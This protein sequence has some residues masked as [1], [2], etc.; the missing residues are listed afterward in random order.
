L[1]SSCRRTT[2]GLAL[3]AFAAGLCGCSESPKSKAGHPAQAVMRVEV[4]KPQRHTVQRAVGEPGQL[5][6]FETTPIHAKIAGY[7]RKVNV[8]IGYEIKKGEVLAE[9]YVPELEAE[10][11]QKSAAVEQAQAKKAQAEAVVKVAVAAIASSE[12]KLTEVQAGVKRSEADLVRWQQEFRRIE[13]LFNERAQTGT[14]LDETRSKL[15]ASEASRDEVRAQVKSAEAAVAEAR[16]SLDQTRSDVTATAASIGVAREDVRR[17]EAMLGYTRIEAPYDGIITRRNVDTGHLTRPGSDAPPLFIAAR[18]DVVTIVVDIPETYAA[19]VEKGDRA[20]VKLQAMKGRIVE[21]TV[22]RTSWA[23]DS[24]TR[25]VRTEIDIPNPGGKLRPG[26]YAYATVIVEEH[27]DVLTI[28]TTAVLPEKEKAFCIVIVEGKAV[29][30]PIGTGLN[31]GTRT[32]VTSGLNGS[33]AVVKTSA[34]SLVEGQAVEVVKPEASAAPPG[35]VP[36]KAAKP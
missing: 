25:T 33:E 29:R 2:T 15:R 19:E 9:L 4:V 26:L 1:N 27:K 35:E 16:A 12:A 14:L 28:P 18:T 13:Q 10:V 21:G 5:V 34:A 22:T 31:D 30:K 11:K 23:L 7:V 8:H 3:A 24:R 6:A 20:T 32:E 17:V 36:P